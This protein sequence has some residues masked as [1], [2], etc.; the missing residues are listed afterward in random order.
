MSA[1][2][3]FWGALRIPAA[4]ALLRRERSLWAPAAL[5]LA[6]TFACFASAA[7]VFFG[8]ALQPFEAW[9]AGALEVCDPSAWYQWLW[10]G[11][12]RAVGWAVRWLLIA[13]LG[14][15][16]F[17]GFTIVGGVLASPFLDVL[18]SRVERLHTGR[19]QQTETAALRSALRIMSADL[20]RAGFFVVGQ[21]LLLALGLLPGLQ[22]IAALATVGFASL[23]LCL[24]Y[25]AYLLDRREIPFRARRAWLWQHRGPAAGFGLAALATFLVPGVNFL[26]LPVLVTAATLLTLDLDPPAPNSWLPS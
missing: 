26:A 13:L 21:L 12:V 5:P 20:K 10:V 14:V 7:G 15:A 8:L 18:S 3:P 25:S 17:F 24:D 4:L 9:I 16:V 22:P 11:P 19:V 2:G 6:L 23:F 1:R